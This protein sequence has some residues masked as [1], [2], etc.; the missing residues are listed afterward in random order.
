MEG[1]CL[2]CQKTCDS[3]CFGTQV[4]D[5]D[6]NPFPNGKAFDVTWYPSNPKADTHLYNGRLVIYMQIDHDCVK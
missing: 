6:P 4:E 3:L 5:S 2:L 1:I